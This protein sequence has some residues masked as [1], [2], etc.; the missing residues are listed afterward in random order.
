MGQEMD[1]RDEEAEPTVK[2]RRGLGSAHVPVT[3]IHASGEHDYSSRSLLASTLEGLEGHVIVDFSGCTFLHSAV[4]GAL[5]RKAIT[6][7]KKG[8]RLE[9]VVPA[10]A[11]FARKLERMRIE[12]LL[13]G[14]DAMPGVPRHARP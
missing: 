10:S 4:I 5:L 12:H 13:P 3:V 6:L 1:R 2:V 9:L 11:S 8:Y 7:A 14:L